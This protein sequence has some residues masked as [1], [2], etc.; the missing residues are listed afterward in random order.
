ME[1][2]KN[3]TVRFFDSE[4]VSGNNCNK[5]LNITA[6][7]AYKLMQAIDSDKKHVVLN[8]EMFATH[9]IVDITRNLESE[10]DETYGLQLTEAQRQSLDVRYLKHGSPQIANKIRSIASKKSMPQING[11]IENPE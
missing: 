5:T 6:E 3:Y 7:M 4:K 11:S 9:Q 10:R 2:I 8:G 1:N